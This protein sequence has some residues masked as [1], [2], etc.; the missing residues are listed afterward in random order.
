[1][2]PEPLFPIEKG[3]YLMEAEPLVRIGVILA[4][5]GKQEVVFHLPAREFLIQAGAREI[6]VQGRMEGPYRVIARERALDLADQ[7]GERVLS[8]EALIRVTPAQS[9]SNLKPGD[10]IRVEDIVAGRGFHWIKQID[11][12]L[13]GE[14][15]FS[16]RD[17]RIV[18]V[19]R[20]PLEEYLT[21]VI[22]GEM[23]GECP[24]EFMKAQAV[25]ARSWLLATPF[26]THPDD[27][28]DWCNDDHC[29]RYQGTSGWSERAI[30][31][32]QGCRGEALITASNRYCDARYS[33]SCGGVSE[34]SSD[35]WPEPIEG[36]QS[37]LDAPR[38]S[39][40]GKFFPLKASQLE[41]YLG[42]SWIGGTDIFCSPAVVPEET[43]TRYLGRV[44]E[45]GRYFRWERTLTQESL[46]QS[47]I[48]RGGLKDL[49]E[50]LDLR[51]VARGKSG[52]IKTLEV[53]YLTGSGE[54]KIHRIEREYYIRAAMSV[55]FLF[56]SAFI[57]EIRRDS[58]GKM[59]EVHIIGGGWGHGAGLCQIGALGM[60]LK[61]YSYRDILLHYYS[62]VR[63]ERIYR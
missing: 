4:E 60:A 22:T 39:E 17:G 63:L 23:S 28:F 58:S 3:N 1:M 24:E 29:Q 34:D 52:R 38:D 54:R 61:G 37:I 40:S 30:R 25:A 42:G 59:I 32:I 31:A 56:S 44:D 15:E 5:D 55:D 41:E 33:K 49:A 14:L 11:Q 6:R 2:K 19:N 47:M 45:S 26:P 16:C 20:L 7:E 12:T 10:G 27:P 57:P 18:M 9:Y 43:I 35:V 36:L 46:R 51:P 8:G 53:E 21:G 48:Q 13:T 50:V 62:D